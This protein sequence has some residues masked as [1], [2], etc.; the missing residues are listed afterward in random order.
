MAKKYEDRQIPLADIDFDLVNARVPEQSSQHEALLELIADQGEKLANLAE[1]I[2]QLGELSPIDKFLVIPGE[3]GRYTSA[4]GNRRLAAMRLMAQPSLAAGTDV[5]RRF[6]QLHAR[7]GDKIP[8]TLDCIVTDRES[9]DL[10]VERK[11][12]RA[13]N[14]VGV[15]QWSSTARTRFGT[16]RRGTTPL[17]QRIIDQV[18]QLPHLTKQERDSIDDGVAASTV[19]RV[20]HDRNF[21]EALGYDIT[22]NEVRAVDP[23]KFM[24]TAKKVVTDIA[25]KKVKVGQVY[26]A[27]DRKRYLRQFS[28]MKPSSNR[29][30]AQPTIV[31]GQKTATIAATPAPAPR[32]AR[33][34]RQRSTLVDPS[35]RVVIRKA[36]PAQLLKEMK[37]LKVADHRMLLAFGLRTFIE[38][39]C[40]EFQERHGAR[41]PGRPELH[42]R[43]GRCEAMLQTLGVPAAELRGARRFANAQSDH[44]LATDT[45]HSYVHNPSFVPTAEDLITQWNNLQPFLIGLWE[46]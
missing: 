45:L 14:G 7:Y 24:Q 21:R 43:I 28:K 42:V 31:I 16:R 9:A 33:G 36:K 10:W 18:R 38:I 35:F 2:G 32:K 37:R 25:S 44:V 23:G 12:D 22:H 41:M 39:S 40:Y 6:N 1:D 5:A 34:Y 13:M 46:K 20:L 3:R 17:A 30:D 19:H 26:D 29:R 27:E 11:H 8:K 15:E 4:E